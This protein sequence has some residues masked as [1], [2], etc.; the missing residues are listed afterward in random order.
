M[1]TEPDRKILLKY[2]PVYDANLS[3][4]SGVTLTDPEITEGYEYL[5]KFETEW[6]KAANVLEYYAS[7]GFKFPSQTPAYLVHPRGTFT[8]F[9]DP[10]TVH[11][12]PDFQDVLATLIHEYCHVLFLY[13]GNDVLA[14][15][16]WNAVQ[17]AFP[18]E[19]FGTQDHIIIN[20]LS[21]ACLYYLWKREKADSVLAKERSLPGLERAWK[22]LDSVELKNTNPIEAIL[23]LCAQQSGK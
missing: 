18:T 2:V 21:E 13:Q 15:K 20:K 22:I 10:L 14:D 17:K 9:S 5:T 6:E 23:E 4:A 7:L 16:I 3:L 12:K 8:P 1:Q 11:I 19:D